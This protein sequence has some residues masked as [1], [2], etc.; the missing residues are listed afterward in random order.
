MRDK[1][2]PYGFAAFTVDPGR[3]PGS[4]TSLHVNYFNVG[5]PD[6]ELHLFES[7]TLQRRRSD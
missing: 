6:G 4:A 1:E 7:F 5:K 2:H 3:G